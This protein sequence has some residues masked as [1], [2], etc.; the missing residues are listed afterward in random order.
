MPGIL[1]VIAGRVIAS[2]IV[3]GIKKAF[4]PNADS[5]NDEQLI[6]D[7]AIEV[8]YRGNYIDC[9]ASGSNSDQVAELKIE[10]RSNK[11][12]SLE[13]YGYAAPIK[14]GLL[15]PFST[16]Y[17]G[18]ERFSVTDSGSPIVL[19]PNGSISLDLAPLAKSIAGRVVSEDETSSLLFDVPEADIVG[20]NSKGES[21]AVEPVAY[22]PHL[23]TVSAF[24]GTGITLWIRIT[25]GA[26]DIN[27]FLFGGWARKDQT[28]SLLSIDKKGNGIFMFMDGFHPAGYSFTSTNGNQKEGRWVEDKLTCLEDCVGAIGRSYQGRVIRIQAVSDTRLCPLFSHAL[29]VTNAP[30]PVN[31]SVEI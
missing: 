5:L 7:S 9:I 10:S 21:V 4:Q 13:V 20:I 29:L 14:G 6:K 31:F 15:G 30:T 19:K 23:P 2:G 26:V 27:K 18:V 3:A 17:Q 28:S 16:H 22:S 12:L 8:F 11:T 24:E 25:L 1:E